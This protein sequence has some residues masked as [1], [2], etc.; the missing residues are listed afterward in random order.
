MNNNLQKIQTRYQK[1]AIKSKKVKISFFM[2]KVSILD[3]FNL[4]GDVY[5]QSGGGGSNT[6]WASTNTNDCG[7]SATP[8]GN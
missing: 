7:S 8:G 6:S 3:Q 1:P 5:A 4:V 2:S